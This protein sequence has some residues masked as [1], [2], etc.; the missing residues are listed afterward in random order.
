MRDARFL[1]IAFGQLVLVAASTLAGHFLSEYNKG[2]TTYYLVPLVLTSIVVFSISY[3]VIMYRHISLSSS[4][5]I[6]RIDKNVEELKQFVTCLA[7]ERANVY[8]LEDAYERMAYAI[9]DAEHSVTL[10]TRHRYNRSNNKVNIP[11]REIKS[12]NKPK[13]YESMVKAIKCQN[14]SFRRLIQVDDD[15]F[16]NWHEPISKSENLAKEIVDV[17]LNKSGKSPRARIYVTTPKLDMSFVLIDNKKLF[18]NVFSVV[19][20]E[21][22][23]PYMFYVESENGNLPHLNEIFE[24]YIDGLQSISAKDAET[25]RELSQEHSLILMPLEG[26]TC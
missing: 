18:F 26:Q 23:S 11:E 25:V 8:E 16:D 12:K 15:L 21:Y 3:I 19:D 9:Q 14:V 20:G 2:E 1:R 24:Q 7:G 22:S 4:E 5:N 13:Y 6:G 10:L 17:Y